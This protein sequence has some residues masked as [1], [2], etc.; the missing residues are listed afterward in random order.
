MYQQL[1]HNLSEGEKILKVSK[2]LNL[3]AGRDEVNKENEITKHEE[4]VV[5]PWVVELESINNVL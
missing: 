4:K 3:G 1:K 5:W 2:P